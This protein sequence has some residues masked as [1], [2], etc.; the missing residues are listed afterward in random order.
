MAHGPITLRSLREREKAQ[1]PPRLG[2]RIAAVFVALQLALLVALALLFPGK[3]G[4]A[5]VRAEVSVNTTGG[6]AR[7]VFALA[8]EVEADVRLNN[9]ILIIAF[10]Q[11]VDVITDLNVASSL[12]DS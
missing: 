2:V 10:K 5:P 1:V 9:G 12:I 11:P 6:Y 4:A 7:L 3:A 8:E